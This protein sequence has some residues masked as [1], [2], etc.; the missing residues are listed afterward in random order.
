MSSCTA[1]GATSKQALSAAKHNV[2][3]ELKRTNKTQF[4]IALA[5]VSLLETVIALSWHSRRRPTAVLGSK[6]AAA[7]LLQ[8]DFGT[9]SSKHV[10]MRLLV[11]TVWVS[12]SPE[13]DLKPHAIAAGFGYALSST[14]AG[15][16]RFH[17]VPEHSEVVHV[18]ALVLRVACQSG[19][20]SHA[21]YCQK[22]SV[23]HK[24]P[25][26]EIIPLRD[27]P[28]V[29]ESSQKQHVPQGLQRCTSRSGLSRAGEVSAAQSPKFASVLRMS[30]GVKALLLLLCLSSS[31]R[32]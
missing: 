21:M 31:D 30:R 18:T 20:S 4:F 17:T 14:Q 11:I 24:S 2:N 13:A 27:R 7:S 8:E 1:A 16:E 10:S 25:P 15:T 32:A 3:I 6:P 9:S 22:P 26:S 12:V 28:P 23:Y 29:T 19:F 5:S